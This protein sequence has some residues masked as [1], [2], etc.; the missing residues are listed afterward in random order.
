MLLDTEGGD[1]ASW[2]RVVSRDTVGDEVS[3][4]EKVSFLQAGEVGGQSTRLAV[5]L[6]YCEG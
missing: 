5:C 2:E 3:K 4:Q 6:C 1:P